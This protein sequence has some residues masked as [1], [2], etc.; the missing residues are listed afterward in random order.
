MKTI[1]NL[2]NMIATI[3]ANVQFEFVK[4]KNYDYNDFL[5]HFD[6]I[7][8]NAKIKSQRKI[9]RIRI[10]FEKNYEFEF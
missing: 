4:R 9:S 1:V 10:I 8:T 2:I 7:Q 3:F 6:A 5:N